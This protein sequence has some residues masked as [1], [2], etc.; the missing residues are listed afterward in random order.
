MDK[1]FFR[2][3]YLQQPIKREPNEAMKSFFVEKAREL[4]KRSDRSNWIPWMVADG[5]LADAERYSVRVVED[6]MAENKERDDEIAR[7]MDVINI[8][9]NEQRKDKQRIEELEADEASLVEDFK[10]VLKERDE[11]FS[12]LR[13]KG[14]VLLDG[15]DDE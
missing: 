2:A 12:I 8:H 4:R 1:D 11:A 3:E 14:I 6:L 7:L 5:I 13:D 15:D 10:K 9:K